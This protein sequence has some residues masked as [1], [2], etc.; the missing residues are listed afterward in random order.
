MKRRLDRAMERCYWIT[1]VY[2]DSEMTEMTV[3][4]A[5]A[6]IIEQHR[7]IPVKLSNS[8]CQAAAEQKHTDYCDLYIDPDFRIRAIEHYSD[9]ASLEDQ[10]A[11]LKTGSGYLSFL[12]RVRLHLWFFSDVSSSW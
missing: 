12:C 9:E 2:R 7:T 11:R 6:S 5:I 4:A 1:P 8:H 3:M 10:M